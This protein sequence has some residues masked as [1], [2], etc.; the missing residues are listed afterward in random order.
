MTL[1]KTLESWLTSRRAWLLKHGPALLSLDPAHERLV[2]DSDGLYGL[3]IEI[4]GRDRIPIFGLPPRQDNISGTTELDEIKCDLAAIAYNESVEMVRAAIDSLA[5]YRASR[6]LGQRRW[7]TGYLRIPAVLQLILSKGCDRPA[8]SFDDVQA[9]FG[10]FSSA[11]MSWQPSAHGSK[12]QLS[13]GCD[14]PTLILS[15]HNGTICLHRFRLGSKPDVLLNIC[16]FRGPEGRHYA[17]LALNTRLPDTFENASIGKPLRF[18]ISSRFTDPFDLN[19]LSIKGRG[20]NL[21]M[22]LSGAEDLRRQCTIFEDPAFTAPYS[23]ESSALDSAREIL[24]KNL[25]FALLP[26]KWWRLFKEASFKPEAPEISVGRPLMRNN[27][28]IL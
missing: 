24:T 16:P 2:P 22:I 5:R 15:H 23:L 3:A 20:K 21:F 14:V 6:S 17:S 26:K 1:A 25:S 12:L 9:M 4:D 11:E 18:V 7:Q 28:W 27:G 19:I 10:R 8:L 13:L